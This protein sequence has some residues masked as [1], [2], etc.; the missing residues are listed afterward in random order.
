MIKSVCLY[1]R[2]RQRSEQP[3]S[4]RVLQEHELHELDRYEESESISIRN[5]GATP[6]EA[7][8]KTESLFSTI[9]PNLYEDMNFI[10]PNFQAP[11]DDE[12]QAHG[13]DN[14]QAHGNDT[15]QA[16]NDDTTAEDD[17]VEKVYL[18]SL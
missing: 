1:H 16:R 14:V 10:N 12:A 9:S 7:D 18:T 8:E 6:R 11:D 2:I 15:L 5:V 4:E 3:I 13:D 17:S